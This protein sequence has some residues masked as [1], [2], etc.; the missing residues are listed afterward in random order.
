M[1]VYIVTEH[2]LYGPTEIV[3]VFDSNSVARRYA[4]EIGPQSDHDDDEYGDA[5]CVTRR[6][7]CW[8]VMTSE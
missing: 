1:I 8:P 3:E 2:V 4:R 7:E 5:H 6:V